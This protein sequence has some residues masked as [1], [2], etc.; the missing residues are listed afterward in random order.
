MRGPA[1]AGGAERLLEVLVYAPVGAVLSAAEEL[2]HWRERGRK[3]VAGQVATARVV[4]E[5]AVRFGRRRLDEAVAS[6][7]TS[8]SE[9]APGRTDRGGDEAV[10]Q[11]PVATVTAPVGQDVGG[12]TGRTVG[13]TRRSVSATGSATF[14][15]K[16]AAGPRASHVP[17]VGSLAIPG[18]DTLSASQ[19]VP[20]LD[21]LGRA[22]LVAVRA[23]E[24]AHRRRRTV[25]GRVD[26]LLAE[27]A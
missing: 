2:P 8:A 6:W 5:L 15:P 18:F 1:E 21:G 14:A 7:A 11:A 13:A 25:L 20:R 23:Y 22:D 4:G 17:P 9:Q 19:V 27:R 3:A 16:A 10:E 24:A 12:T 26:Q